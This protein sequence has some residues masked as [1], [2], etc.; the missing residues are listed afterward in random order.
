MASRRKEC[1]IVRHIPLT[2]QSVQGLTWTELYCR[3]WIKNLG[4]VGTVGT[5]SFAANGL[6]TFQ[7]AAAVDRVGQNEPSRLQGPRLPL[8]ATTSSPLQVHQ[9]WTDQYAVTLRAETEWKSQHSV[10]LPAWVSHCLMAV[11]SV[12]PNKTSGQLVWAWH[13]FWWFG[14]AMN[15]DL[16][17]WVY[18]MVIA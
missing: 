7:S 3:D 13:R 11:V 14:G 10:N 18:T 17:F 16:T 5:S 4:L 9:D 2:I 1:R 8:P 12:T 6:E 15:G